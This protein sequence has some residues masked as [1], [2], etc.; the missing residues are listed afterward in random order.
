MSFI[1]ITI[2]WFEFL[3]W[4][5][6]YNHKIQTLPLY[7]KQ[8]K[9][10]LEHLGILGIKLGQYICN[11][12]DI[13]SDIM[14][15]ELSLFLNHNKIHPI[16]Y[17]KSI[18]ENANVDLELAEVIGSGSMCQVYKCKMKDERSLVLKVRHPEV[19]LLSSEIK[20]VKMLI[21]K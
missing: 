15:K 6:F 7:S 21:K 4:F 9:E 19:E 14:K 2:K 5:Y 20:V 3:I 17:T 8:F 16:H 13:C 11:R 12:E 1:W 10:R 18:L